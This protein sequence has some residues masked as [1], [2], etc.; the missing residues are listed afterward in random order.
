MQIVDGRLVLS[1]GDLVAHLAC[2]HLSA[3]D[4]QVAHGLLGRP[5]RV[6]PELD[7]LAERGARH[8]TTYVARLVAEGVDLVDL[9]TGDSAAVPDGA[10]LAAAETLAAMREGRGAIYQGTFFDGGWVGRPDLLRRVDRPSPAFGAWSYEVADVKL[11]RSVKASA[12]VQVALYADQLSRLQGAE[13]AELWVVTG[14]GVEHGF[15][16]AEHVP[17]VRRARARLEAWA[18]SASAGP[19]SDGGV[20]SAPEPVEHC[21]V[22][23]WHERCGEQWRS[24]DHLS[25]VPRLRRDQR[26]KLAVAGITSVAALAAVDPLP[27]GTGIGDTV[28]RGHQAQAA[29]QVRGRE[30]GEPLYEL[31]DVAGARGLAALPEPCDGDLF[32]DIE[33]DPF[34]VEG[35]LEYLFGIVEIVAG[36]PVYHA[37]WAHDPDEERR[38]FEA[39]IDRFMSRLLEHPEP[40]GASPLVVPHIYHYAPYESSV[41]RRLAGRYA[42]REEEV[43][44]LLRGGVL[45][46]LYEVVRQGVRVSQ[47]SYSIK[48]LEPFYMEAR[49]TD[50]KAGASSIV[51]YEEWL[52]T[53]DQALLDGLAAYNRDDCI[54]T[55]KL[56]G[57]LEA[58][59]AELVEREP[60]ERPVPRSRG[61]SEEREEASTA[62]EAL[63]ARLRELAADGADGAVPDGRRA[64]RLLADLLD[65][66]RREQRSEWWDHF[67]R[68]EL[69]N[70]A[71]IQDPA[72]LGG[73]TYVGEVGIVKL[74]VVHEYSFEPLQDYRI[75]V[76]TTPLDPRTGKGAGTVEALDS[77][78]GVIRLV[79]GKRSAAPHP[80]ALVPPGPRSVAGKQAAMSRV[81]AWVADNG[82]DAPGAYRAVRELLLRRAPQISGLPA[83]EALVSEGEDGC[84]AARRLVG[85]LDGGV[86]A[87]QGPPGAG[88][89]FTAG[90]MIVDLVREGRRVG[91]CAPSHRAIGNLVSEVCERARAEGTSL[92]VGQ[93]GAEGEVVVDDMVR[94]AGSAGDVAHWLAAGEVEV[95]AGTSWLFGNEALDGAL[96]VLF[97]D[98]AGQLS[99]ADAVAAGTAATN[100]VLLGD[101]Q[102]LSQVA[103]GVHPPGADAS[104]LGHVLGSS[105]TIAPARGVFL[106][107]TFRMHPALCGL[108]SELFYDGRLAA[109]DGMELQGVRH[110]GDVLGDE[111][112]IALVAVEH[113]GNRT[114]SREEVDAVAAIV[115]SLGGA[116]WTDHAGHARPLERR[117]ILVVAPYNAQVVRLSTA[118]GGDIEVGT[119][120]KLQGQEAPVVIYSTAGSDGASLPRGIEFLFSKNRL[121]VALSRARALVVVVSSPSLLDVPCRRPE[122]IPLVSAHCRVAELATVVPVDAFRVQPGGAAG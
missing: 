26:R 86:L 92:R 104:A 45:V 107:R 33:G 6:D 76:G 101:P 2:E 77:A 78:R 118:L 116:T 102:Q 120:D 110:A 31:L 79:R 95:V 115:D 39:V 68:L 32:F 96:D 37:T 83:G 100:L 13:P 91:I 57:W 80:T 72:A 85:L 23:R 65:W 71:L 97:I 111:A 109:A 15:A 59:R 87:V 69:S 89:T 28:L 49:E 99:L 52:D 21:G 40:D 9:S 103:K 94:P 5:D 20:G 105:A 88:K 74:S 119:V 14:D 7:V 19:A 114:W 90:H 12:L 8:E 64:T 10:A 82:I 35:G 53:H 63:A 113:E 108:I 1:A 38:A 55:W 30:R 41:L 4:L 11:A 62:R 117:D 36:E 112:G 17:Y 34:A 75:V 24:E 61:A 70:D 73:L 60:V 93:R 54:S 56:R 46:D 106:D 48:A 122:Q 51:A 67:R 84:T 16:V 47:E 58:R 66:H 27:A 3:L 98:E 25:L 43:D 121:D 18:R 22:C 50:V 81:G 44:Q 29:L 42:T